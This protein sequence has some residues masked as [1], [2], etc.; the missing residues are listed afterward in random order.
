VGV[1]LGSDAYRALSRSVIT[2][3]GLDKL[4]KKGGRSE[5]R[6]DV[7]VTAGG[8]GDMVIS[9]VDSSP[10]D[11]VDTRLSDSLEGGVV[12]ILNSDVYAVIYNVS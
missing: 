7:V 6:R 9:L 10:M 3:G 11:G 4:L 8:G 5:E 1:G 12:V 2:G